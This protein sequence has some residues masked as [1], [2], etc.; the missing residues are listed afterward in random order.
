MFAQRN[1][2]IPMAAGLSGLPARDGL[3]AQGVDN[4]MDKALLSQLKGEHREIY[5]TMNYFKTEEKKSNFAPFFLTF[6]INNFL[7]DVK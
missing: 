6:V 4:Q 5:P 3:S 7:G 1:L 2:N